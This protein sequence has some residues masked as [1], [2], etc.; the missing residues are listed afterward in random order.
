[1]EISPKFVV[2]QKLI[3]NKQ[4]LAKKKSKNQ[5]VA[6]KGANV[7][8]LLQQIS[9]V[10]T[11]SGESLETMQCHDISWRKES[12]NAEM[13]QHHKKTPACQIMSTIQCRDIITTWLQHQL[14]KERTA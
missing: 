1:M 14:R 6:K 11:L 12:N 9:N 4:N 13:S 7:A 2:L 10:A 5:H 8:T 3:R